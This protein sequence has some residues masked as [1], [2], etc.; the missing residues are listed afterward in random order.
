MTDKTA[1]ATTTTGNVDQPVEENRGKN[2]SHGGGMSPI[3]IC[4]ILTILTV[5]GVMLGFANHNALYVAF[6]ILP[7][8]AYEIYRTKGVSTIFASWAI[9]AVIL[10]EIIFLIFHINYDL[11]QYLGMDYTYVGGQYVPLGDIKIL[12]PALLAVFSVILFIRTAGPY[13]KWLSVIIFISAFLMVYI[14][15]PDMFRELIRSAVRSITWY[16]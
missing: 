6:F 11:G 2:N 3:L 7:A 4:L 13:T 14:M 5:I 12:G 10:A 9:L 16:L 1:D 15:S 8:V